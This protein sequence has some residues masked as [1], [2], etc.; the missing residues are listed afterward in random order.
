MKASLNSDNINSV[1]LPLISLP[2]LSLLRMNSFLTRMAGSLGTFSLFTE[3]AWLDWF[4][5]PTFFR[6]DIALAL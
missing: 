4:V 2:K 6:L 5:T 3:L 1:H